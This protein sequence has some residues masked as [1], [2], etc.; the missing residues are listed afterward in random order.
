MK[1]Y[2]IFLK[3]LIK[4]YEERVKSGIDEETAI[5]FT[6]EFQLTEPIFEEN[7]VDIYLDILENEGYISRKYIHKFT[8]T[9]KA[10][11]F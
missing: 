5:S 1:D 10:L 11:N 2:E 8:L 7:N 6:K 4:I 9:D 3:K